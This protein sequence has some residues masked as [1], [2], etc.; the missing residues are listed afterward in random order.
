LTF[1]Q[2]FEYFFKHINGPEITFLRF[3]VLGLST[4]IDVIHLAEHIPLCKELLIISTNSFFITHQAVL[5]LEYQY[6]PFI[7]TF[8]P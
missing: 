6:F 4:T 8:F 5:I 2:Q 1:Y 7:R 3:I